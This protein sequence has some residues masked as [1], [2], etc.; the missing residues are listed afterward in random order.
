MNDRQHLVLDISN[1]SNSFEQQKIIN[2][3]SLPESNIPK[4]FLKQEANSVCFGFYVSFDKPLND[5][6]IF[7]L[8]KNKKWF[9]LTHIIGNFLVIYIN[10]K[11]KNVYVLSD[12]FGSFPCYFA[13]EDNKLLIS[14]N[15]GFLTR[16]LKRRDFNLDSGLDYVY[17]NYTYSPTNQTIISQIS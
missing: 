6:E 8:C 5:E 2:S 14:T 10:L 13:I 3:L 16:A 4:S 7:S 9:E 15:F 11:E 1:L 12:I 17:S